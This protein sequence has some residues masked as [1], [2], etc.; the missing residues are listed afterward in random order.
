MPVPPPEPFIPYRYQ[1]DGDPALINGSHEE[2]VQAARHLYRLAS[3]MVTSAAAVR[4]AGPEAD[5]WRRQVQSNADALT[6]SARGIQMAGEGLGDWSAS[7][8]G[9][10]ARM[11]PVEAAA[12]VANANVVRAFG[13]VNV[14]ESVML[15]AEVALASAESELAAA[16][17][18]AGATM[19]A[20]AA[21]VA[22]AAAHVAQA[23]AELTRATTEVA[24]AHADHA[25]WT[26]KWNAANTEADGIQ[27]QLGTDAE[28]T[29]ST[30]KKGTGQESF[31]NNAMAQFRAAG[32]S[33]K[34]TARQVQGAVGEVQN[35]V[36]QASSL[37]S[38]LNNGQSGTSTDDTGSTEQ[39]TTAQDDK[40]DTAQS[41]STGT[42]PSTFDSGTDA[43]DS[44]AVGAPSATSSSAAKSGANSKKSGSRLDDQENLDSDEDEPGELEQTPDV[45]DMSIEDL[46]RLLAQE[47][48]ATVGRR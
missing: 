36:S 5:A 19:G 12:Q 44:T 30:V 39:R 8:A 15:T 11:V 10:Q 24:A 34:N 21:A 43:G 42:K 41:T 29:S 27:A 32:D 46:G 2:W 40:P 18:A 7:L 20:A 37:T 25:S 1:V 48:A 31:V 6:E 28:R 16:S 13:R 17:A 26:G 22:A 47:L 4:F 23:T 33:A 35:V 9:A 45:E 14:A 38:S 3:D